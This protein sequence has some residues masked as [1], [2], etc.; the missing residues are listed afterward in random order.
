[1]HAQMRHMSLHAHF[2]LPVNLSASD[3]TMSE[4]TPAK[5]GRGRSAIRHPPSVSE[6]ATYSQ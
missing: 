4:K 5:R 3:H 1:M 2:P 6:S